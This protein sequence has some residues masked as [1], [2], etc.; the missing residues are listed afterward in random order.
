MSDNQ[1]PLLGDPAILSIKYYDGR[2]PEVSDIPHVVVP[3]ACRYPPN[4]LK[5]IGDNDSAGS[6]FVPTVFL[7]Q[8]PE[9]EPVNWRSL[10]RK[11]VTGC[12][13]A[14]REREIAHPSTGYV[15]EHNQ[16]VIILELPDEKNVTIELRQADGSGN[17][18]TVC[19][20]GAPLRIVDTASGLHLVEGYA[21][22][23]ATDV[24][25]QTKLRDWID[26]LERSGVTRYRLRSDRGHRYWIDAVLRQFSSFI[27]GRIPDLEHESE[28]VHVWASGYE[29]DTL[30]TN[31]N[32]TK[33][34]L[35]GDFLPTKWPRTSHLFQSKDSRSG[36]RRDKNSQTPYSWREDITF[37]N[38]KKR[39]E[40]GNTRSVEHKP[41]HEPHHEPQP[42]TPDAE[43]FLSPKRAN[44]HNRFGKFA[45][46]D[47][48]AYK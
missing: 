42:K 4:E 38:P 32:S 13:L 8:G 18:I 41:H 6:E 17:T 10:L 21:C 40:R 43:P 24:M 5:L 23:F 29:L 39:N 2:S 25:V 35:P 22:T 33:R 36:E 46:W 31:K 3:N 14:A 48:F 16:W 1:S 15:L 11:K 45:T 34:I 26:R 20:P 47:R 44:P 19:R 7:C 9:Q 27:D 28:M 12:W 37:V 30:E